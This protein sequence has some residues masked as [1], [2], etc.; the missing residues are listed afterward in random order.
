LFRDH[1]QAAVS[2]MPCTSYW[3]SQSGTDGLACSAQQLAQGILAR[4]N[5]HS[6]IQWQ[7]TQAQADGQT[8]GNWPCDAMAQSHK[9][10]S[11]GV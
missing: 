9:A 7:S 3:L 1:R 8:R 2:V 6:Q 5:F 4:S 11:A 10:T